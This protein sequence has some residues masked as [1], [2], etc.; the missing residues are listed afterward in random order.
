MSERDMPPLA[1]SIPLLRP[2]PLIFD[3]D[4]TV[5]VVVYVQ[6]PGDWRSTQE[7]NQQIPV[8]KP[9]LR[10]YEYGHYDRWGGYRIEL[11]VAAYI[12]VDLLG[13]WRNKSPS[14]AGFC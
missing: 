9:R 14:S 2:Y 3:V 7:W 8:R 6:Y 1:C 10:Q 12:H 5:V 11:V 13:G 4:L